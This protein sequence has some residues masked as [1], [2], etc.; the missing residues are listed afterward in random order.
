MK[1]IKIFTLVSIIAIVSVLFGLTYAFFTADI[2][3][4]NSQKINVKTVSM[5]L[6][7]SDNDNGISAV[8]SPGQSV[9]KLFTVENTGNVGAFG[10]VKWENLTNNYRKDTLTYTLSESDTEDG[11][12][13]PLITGF[14][15]TKD[16]SAIYNGIY[17]DSGKKKYYKLV[18]TLNNLSYANQDTDKNAS[19]NTKFTMEAGSSNVY[20]QKTLNVLSKLNSN[21]KLNTTTLDY[22]Y[23]SEGAYYDSNTDEDKIDSSKISNGI[24]Q[25]P[26]DKGESYIFRGNIDYNYLKFA[27]FYWRILRI[28][29]DGTLRLVYDGTKAHANTD[30]CANK[31]TCDRIIGTTVYNTKTD[32]NAYI[33]YMYGTPGSTTYEETHANKNNSNIKTFIDDWYKANIV[34]KNFGEYVADEI[35]CNDR[36]IS[37]ELKSTRTLDSNGFNQKGYGKEGTLYSSSSRFYTN[38]T[39][40]ILTCPQKNDAFTVDDKVYGNGALTYPIALLTVDEI[41]FAGGFFDGNNSFY[42]NDGVRYWTMTPLAYHAGYSNAF[43]REVYKGQLN[44]SVDT[45]HANISVVPVINLK[46]DAVSKLTGNGT[47]DSPFEISK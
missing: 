24:Y 47:T 32:D 34:D 11:T 19:L 39:M 27:D 44:N 18:I 12:Y 15:P 6:I 20:S 41:Q 16:D 45:T 36:S 42:L 31:E 25:A 9:T 5:Q 43:I 37:G 3:N 1:K 10:K 29:G 23:S 22:K 8:M 7:F 14:V 21:I 4:S 13:I 38:Y 35:F 17:V 46:T 40:P 28:N 2:D 33:G 26:D 30:L